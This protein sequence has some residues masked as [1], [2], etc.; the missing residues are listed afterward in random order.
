LGLAIALDGVNDSFT[1]ADT[2]DLNFGTGDFTIS[3]WIRPARDGVA[4]ALVSKRTVSNG[5]ELFRTSDG[6]LSFFGAGCGIAVSGGS[7]PKDTWHRVTA[8]R[9]AGTIFLYVDDAPAG[10]AT[11][12]DD[13]MNGAAFAVGCQADLACAEPF[14]GRIDDV[15]VRKKAASAAALVNELCADQVSAGVDPL[16]AACHP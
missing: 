10:S 5:Y 12:A 1:V 8:T 11:C 16:P 2:N 14:Q 7:L 6:R 3:T 4:E 15:S 9:N 13:F